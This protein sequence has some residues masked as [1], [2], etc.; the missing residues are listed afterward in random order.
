MQRRFWLALGIVLTLCFSTIFSAHGQT[1]QRSL[2]FTDHLLPFQE[3][4]PA[5]KLQRAEHCFSSDGRCMMFVVATHLLNGERDRGRLRQLWLRW[6]NRNGPDY[7]YQMARGM[8]ATYLEC[9]MRGLDLWVGDLHPRYC[10]SPTCE[11]AYRDYLP[12]LS[13][14]ARTNCGITIELPKPL[15][16]NPQPRHEERNVCNRPCEPCH[17]TRLDCTT[18]ACGR[19]CVWQ[20]Y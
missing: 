2:E 17:N 1:N 19:R 7:W 18:D 16:S 12:A 13:T 4:D 6:T 3:L 10:R 15:Y 9:D 11:A 5:V 8:I 14:L 20:P